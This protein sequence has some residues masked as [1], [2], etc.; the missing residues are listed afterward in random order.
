MNTGLKLQEAE[1]LPF[2]P[3]LELLGVTPSLNESTLFQ[4]RAYPNNSKV[5]L[6]LGLWWQMP[7]LHG[8]IRLSEHFSGSLLDPIN[9]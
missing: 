8:S 1:S 9:G 5:R 3:V 2:E 4:C 6:S 7:D